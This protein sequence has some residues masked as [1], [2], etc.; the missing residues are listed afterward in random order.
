[1]KVTENMKY[2]KEMNQK[3]KHSKF[4]THQKICEKIKYEYYNRGQTICHYGI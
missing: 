1:M 2:F 4:Q 3:K